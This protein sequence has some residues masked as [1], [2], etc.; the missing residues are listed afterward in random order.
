M[1]ISVNRAQVKDLLDKDKNTWL[2]AQ[3]VADLLGYT[4][5]MKN[6]SN[7]L[8][9]LFTSGY[10]AKQKKQNG[11]GVEYKV[12]GRGNYKPRTKQEDLPLQELTR[13]EPK[14]VAPMMNAEFEILSTSL[15]KIMSDNNNMRTA[16]IQCRDAID[17]ALQG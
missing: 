16:L 5:T 3:E 6:V 10:V 8:S 11:R 17:K 7:A 15:G 4:G 13:D 12:K 1:T 2:T 14:A 9:G